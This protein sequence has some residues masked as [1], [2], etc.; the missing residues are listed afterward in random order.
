MFAGCDCRWR[1]G[2]LFQDGR[3]V[4]REEDITFL[5]PIPDP[6]KIICIGKDYRAHTAK[7]GDVPAANPNL[8]IQL[9]NT[10]VPHGGALVRPMDFEQF[11][12]EGKLALVIGQAGRHITPSDALSHVAGYACCNDASVRDDQFR[13][14]LT[15]GQSFNAT[16]GFGP[17][18][19]TA[20]EIIEV[21]H[22]RRRI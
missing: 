12:Y 4:L 13:H 6:E 14:S 15:A 2:D 8:L 9:V 19:I 22:G 3:P 10:L 1:P 5:P 11:D 18:L 20:D 16:G 7:S 17:W 21:Q